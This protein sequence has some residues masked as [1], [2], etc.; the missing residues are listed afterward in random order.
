LIRKNKTILI[1]GGA[2]YQMLRM[3]NRAW[4]EKG[5]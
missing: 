4:Q 1:I 2:K 3:E 5:S